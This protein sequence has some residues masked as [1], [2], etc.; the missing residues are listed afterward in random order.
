MADLYIRL[1]VEDIR[2]SMVGEN[3]QVITK[4]ERFHIIFTPAALLE[5]AKDIQEVINEKQINNS[6]ECETK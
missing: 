5:L 4:D 2:T 1:D 6:Q 3:I